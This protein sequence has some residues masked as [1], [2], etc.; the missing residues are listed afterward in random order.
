MSASHQHS[1]ASE[2]GTH[3]GLHDQPA[4]HSD[5]EDSFVSAHDQ[6][7]DEVDD[8]DDLD[9]VGGDGHDDVDEEDEDDEEYEDDEVDEDDDEDYEFHGIK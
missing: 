9:Y 5:G 7:L 3:Q 2:G 6:A 1:D 4:T 8:E